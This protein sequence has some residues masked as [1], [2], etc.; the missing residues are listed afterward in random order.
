MAA[1]NLPFPQHL[2]PAPPLIVPALLVASLIFMIVVLVLGTAPDSPFVNRWIRSLG[3][4]SF[5][6][7]L[8]HFA[9]LHKLPL[10]LPRVFD[11]HATGWRAIFIWF[12]LWVTAVLSHPRDFPAD[13]RGCREP[14]DCPRQARHFSYRLV[15]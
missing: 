8:L 3:Q 9:V 2:P 7:Y 14:D 1:A 4:V 13:L 12:G 15:L 11:L 6:A 5:S 10:L